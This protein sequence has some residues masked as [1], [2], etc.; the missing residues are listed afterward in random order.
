MTQTVFI[1]Q[2]K[3]ADYLKFQHAH[4]DSPA[5]QFGSKNIPAF[6]GFLVTPMHTEGLEGS[7]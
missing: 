6:W 2:L 5:V 3:G 1:S 4:I 7:S